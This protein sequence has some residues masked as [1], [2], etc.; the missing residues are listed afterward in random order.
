M[1]KEPKKI[2][3][4]WGN[5][6][7][8]G[9]P[10]VKH[11]SPKIKKLIPASK[12]YVEPL[13]GLGR[14]CDENIHEKVVLNDMSDYAI[15]YLKENFKKS[16][17]TQIDFEECIRIWDSPDTFFLFD[18][19]WDSDVYNINSLPYCNMKAPQYYDRLLEIVKTLKGDWII[20]STVNHNKTIRD[21]LLKTNYTKCVVQSD[22]KVLFGRKAKTMLTSNK[23]FTVYR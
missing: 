19:P 21:K 15:K 23:P 2:T 9:Y 17:I 4:V 13:A 5:K 12:I 11:T 16:E 8:G 10:G 7:W 18:P 6:Q 1:M 14:T 20:L 3:S 22:K